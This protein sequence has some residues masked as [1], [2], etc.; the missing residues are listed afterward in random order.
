MNTLSTQVI[1]Q[2]HHQNS[3]LLGTGFKRTLP[4]RVLPHQAITYKL[5]TTIDELEEAFNLLYHSSVDVRFQLPKEAKLRFTK[6]HLLPST[7]ILI[8][9]HRPEMEKPKPD[10]TKI[11]H[12]KKI[13]GTLTLVMDTAMK[14]PMDEVCSGNVDKFRKAGRKPAEIISLAVHP[15]FQNIMSTIRLFRM[16]TYYARLHDVTDIVA[17][18]TPRHNAFYRDILLFKVYDKIQPH[19]SDNDLEMQCHVQDMSTVD[20][21]Y[22]RTYGT[23][24]FDCNLA[25]FFKSGLVDTLQ[26]NNTW[27]EETVNYFLSLH[28]PVMHDLTPDDI[29]VLRYH[30]AKKG[31][32][33]PL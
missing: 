15:R 13:I 22:K 32:S 28:D 7:K 2:N 27:S 14:L 31:V 24:E 19:I 8:A 6:Y 11:D 12:N 26:E 17:S 21:A 25:D 29:D 33:F 3:D 30:Y 23:K 16:M 5:A 20:E 1:H 10:S 18:V 4:P 9:V